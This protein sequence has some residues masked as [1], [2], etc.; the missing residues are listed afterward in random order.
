MTHSLRVVSF[1]GG[2]TTDDTR[3][4]SKKKPVAEQHLREFAAKVIAA[5]ADVVNLQEC[6]PAWAKFLLAQMSEYEMVPACT[7]PSLRANYLVS[8]FRSRIMQSDGGDE[9]SPFAQSRGKHLRDRRAL[10][11]TFTH[12]PSRQLCQVVNWH[13]V[14]GKWSWP[15][16]SLELKEEAVRRLV[17][18]C[19]AVEVAVLAAS[20]DKD[21]I[22]FPWVMTGDFNKLT[23]YTCEHVLN[24]LPPNYNL[25]SRSNMRDHYITNA[26]PEDL[27]CDFDVHS[28]LDGQHSAFCLAGI[29]MPGQA[30]TG[31]R[32]KKRRV[33]SGREKQAEELAAAVVDESTGIVQKGL[34]VDADA[35]LDPVQGNRPAPQQSSPSSGYVQPTQPQSTPVASAPS[36][37]PP[38]PPQNTLPPQPQGTPV[39]KPPPPQNTLQPQ[40]QST[41]VPKPPPPQAPLPMPQQNQLPPPPPPPLEAPSSTSTV[42]RNPCHSAGQCHAMLQPLPHRRAMRYRCNPIWV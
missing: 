26:D 10:V 34:A 35:A 25:S 23:N 38:P 12:K 1:N 8:F 3:T 20:Q 32:L 5:K 6:S 41:P 24:S 9:V 37:A 19:H 4:S 39:A 33:R 7:M 36:P 27:V 30:A 16:K 17:Q 18:N 22:L 2:F 31:Q 14:D 11:M 28:A 29:P 42:T 13:A 15:G 21:N 40:P